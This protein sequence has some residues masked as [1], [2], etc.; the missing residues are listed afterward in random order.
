LKKLPLILLVFWFGCQTGVAQFERNGVPVSWGLTDQPDL[1]YAWQALPEIDQQSLMLEDEAQM[2]DK[3][4]PF[5]FAYA[6]STDFT[7]NNSGQWNNLLN[8]DRIW[9]LGIEFPDV[10]SISL[11]LRNIEIPRGGRVY[12]YNVDH[13]GYI[14]PIT[15]KDNSSGFMGIPHIPGSKIIIEYYEPYA[16]RGDGSFRIDH[17][18]G[19]YRSPDAES[20]FSEQLC[21]QQVNPQNSLDGTSRIASSVMM[22][23]VDYGQKMSTATILNNSRV[24]AMPY[25][26]TAS[27]SLLGPASSWVFYFDINRFRCHD[28]FSCELRA[29]SGAAIVRNDTDQGISLLRLIRAPL[30]GWDTFF[31]GWVVDVDEPNSELV[32]LHHAAA[33][34]LALTRYQNA[35]TESITDGRNL[36]SL[37]MNSA[38]KTF[39]GSIGAP[40]FD[41][42]WNLIGVFIG[43]ND[44][45][46]VTGSDQFALLSE[47]WSSLRSFLDPLQIV[48]DRIPG[49]YPDVAFEA[50]EAVSEE[51]SFFPNPA[52]DWIYVR[53]D[54]ES[55]ILE[56]KLLNAVGQ[57]IQSFQPDVPTISIAGLQEGLYMIEFVTG[58][59]RYTHQLLVR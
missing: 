38:G 34:N 25:A 36:V 1:G 28:F 20:F 51:I 11:T 43:G 53:N 33:S 14:G 40:L 42:E 19:A 48:Q 50:G 46:D 29:L 39:Q 49:Y 30:S 8:G 56:V 22:M 13:S 32:C 54:S 27:A 55:R 9:I 21:Y 3:S 6:H 15:S 52:K 23:M 18:A 2:E 7:L 31:S 37:E 24:D 45:C 26:L 59:S 17:V 44:A 35:W 12:F 47:S 58:K 5:R 57:V 16:Y 10:L 4:K 41:E